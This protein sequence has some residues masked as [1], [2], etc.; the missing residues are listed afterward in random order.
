ME[1]GK[2]IIGTELKTTNFDKQIKAVETRLEELDK[3]AKEPIVL[4]SGVKVYG[5][6][7]LT[8][9]EVNEYNQLQAELSK[10]YKQKLEV[11]KVEKSISNELSKQVSLTKQ[12]QPVQ[13]TSASTSDGGN[14]KK[15]VGL[16][17]EL[18]DIV[19]EYKSIQSADIISSKD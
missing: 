11:E 16:S 10:L 1:Q 14:A 7:N 17:A 9:D 3:K 8:E 2:V 4:E 18:E 5:N 6:D 19:K 15:I 12:A 13:Q